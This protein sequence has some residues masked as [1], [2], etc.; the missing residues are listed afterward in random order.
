MVNLNSK[1][2]AFSLLVG[3]LPTSPGVLRNPQCAPMWLPEE[4]WN[5]HQHDGKVPKKE[6]TWNFG[7]WAGLHTPN[8][9]PPS[10]CCSLRRLLQMGD[11]II[12]F[13]QCFG[14]LISIWKGGLAFRVIE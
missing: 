11:T 3:G 14:I 12:F 4:G 6:E 8:T 1:T 5:T 10:P 7:L 2:L 9:V 13:F